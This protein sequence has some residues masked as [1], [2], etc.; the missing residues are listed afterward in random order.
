MLVELKPCPFCGTDEG[1]SI[2]RYDSQFHR[3]L[4]YVHCNKCEVNSVPEPTVEKAIEEWNYS[5]SEG[6]L[7]GEAYENEWGA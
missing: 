2:E 4:F 7:G 3:S 6:Y 5:I 1:L